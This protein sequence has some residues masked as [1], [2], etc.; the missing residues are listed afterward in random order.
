MALG[1][2]KFRVKINFPWS[3]HQVGDVIDTYEGIC[4]AYIVQVPDDGYGCPGESEKYDLRDFPE[5]YE[6]IK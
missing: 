1:T 5:I 2:T 6:Q 4:R 3:M